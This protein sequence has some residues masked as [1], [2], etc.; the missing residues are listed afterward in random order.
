M[1]VLANKD[2]VDNDK[3]VISAETKEFLALLYPEPKTLFFRKPAEVLVEIDLSSP[4]DTPPQ[5]NTPEPAAQETIVS[6][7]TPSPV[8]IEIADLPCETDRNT[9]TIAQQLAFTANDALR[10]LKLK[11]PWG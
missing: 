3:I 2:A 8:L 4:N 10:R 9:P 6:T 1:F 7:T 11:F 5:S